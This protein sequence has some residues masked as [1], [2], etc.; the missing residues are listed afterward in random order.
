MLN[1]VFVI[2]I[3]NIIVG[4]HISLFKIEHIKTVAN[5]IAFEKTYSLIASQEYIGLNVAES[6]FKSWNEISNFEAVY[7]SFYLNEYHH[8]SDRFQ[9]ISNATFVS[10]KMIMATSTYMDTVNNCT[11]EL[12]IGYVALKLATLENNSKIISYISDL[13]VES[14]FRKQGIEKT[15]LSAIKLYK[16]R[17]FISDEEIDIEYLHKFSNIDL[18]RR[19]SIVAMSKRIN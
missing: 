18:N 4:Y 19:K 14:S 2:H 5:I 17:G 9:T 6:F 8:L 11:N 13:V 7:W 3:I 1:I 15:N 12:L 10:E 16:R